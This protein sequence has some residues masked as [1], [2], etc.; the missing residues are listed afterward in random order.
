MQNCII[1]SIDEKNE[2]LQKCLVKLKN[3][4]A[5]GIGIWIF[6]GVCVQYIIFS[7]YVCSKLIFSII[8]SINK[9]NDMI[10]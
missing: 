2:F 4:A 10:V 5:Y 7:M 1:L 6:W 3:Y 8:A 9:T